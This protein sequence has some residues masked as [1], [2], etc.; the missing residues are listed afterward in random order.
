MGVAELVVD[1]AVVGLGPGGE[2]V[3]SRL[4]QAGQSVAGIEA[5]LV[6]GECPYYACVPTKGMIRAADVL[7]EARR[8]PEFAGTAQVTPDWGKVAARVRDEITTDW[9]DQ[10]AVDRLVAAGVQIVRGRARITEPGV[11]VVGDQVVRARR[12]IVLNPG[13]D[14]AVPP[15]PG[16]ADTPLWTNREAVRAT[17]VPESLVVIGGGPVGC[18]FAQVFARFGAKVTLLQSNDRLLPLDEPEA[19]ALLAERFAAEHIRVKTGA[20][21][22]A[23]RHDGE[24]FTVELDG[25]NPINAAQVLVAAGRKSDLAELGVGAYG[26]D[27]SARGVTVDDH[28]RVADG[29][30]AIGD[31]TGKGAFTHMSMYQSA[32]AAADILGEDGPGAEY[33]AVPR[34]TFTDPE[35]GSVGLTEAAARAAGL[36][37]RVGITQLSSSTRGFLHKAEGLIKLIE[38]ADT[39]VLVGATSAGPTGGEVLGALVLAVHARVPV[40]QL[41][42]MIYAYPTFHRAIESALADLRA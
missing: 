26:L 17:A 12:G 28:M 6:G 15:V 39:G 18:E 21:I 37:V 14:P 32:I 33:H 7:A 34:V 10:A 36:N 25:D 11:L 30:W 23:V 4:A 22:T 3:A 13:T 29:L 2:A 19:G 42:R 1:V 38:D 20:K 40:D 16:L 8:V 35:I 5:R 41:R 9:N 27:E 24:R 31:I